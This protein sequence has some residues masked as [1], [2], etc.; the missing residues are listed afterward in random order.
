MSS[1]VQDQQAEFSDN[2]IDSADEEEASQPEIVEI[3]MIAKKWS[4]EPATITV[5]EGDTVLLH[6]ESIDVTHGLKMLD[7]EVDE[8]LIP[9]ETVDIQFVADKKGTFTF[10][11]SVYCGSGHNYMT[12]QLIVN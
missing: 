2:Y 4:F 7:F 9:G 10:S 11:C 8:N 3:S 6:V 5:N 12:G 1:D